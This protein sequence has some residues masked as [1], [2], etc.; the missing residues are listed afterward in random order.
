MQIGVAAGHAG[1]RRV[2]DRRRASG[3]HHSPLG[4]SQLGQALPDAVHDFVELC[5]LL[6]GR[7]LRGAHLR[8]F[9]GS[10]DDRQRAAAVDK[11]PHAYR[12]V[13]VRLGGCG[14]DGRFLLS[15]CERRGGQCTPDT[16][17]P[18]EAQEVTTSD[19]RVHVRVAPFILENEH[20]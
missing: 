7:G 5:V 3:A 1:G 6:I 14:R 12:C 10:A 9:D 13:D 18:R 17:Q 11:G 16:E 15:S 19:H 8:Q 4:S 20:Q 2:R